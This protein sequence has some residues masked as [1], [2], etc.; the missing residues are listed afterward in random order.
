[1][2]ITNPTL[3]E[4]SLGYAADVNEIPVEN[5]AG[6]NQASFQMIFPVVTEQPIAAG[7][8]PPARADFN[9]L[10]KLLGDNIYFL[11]RGGFYQYDQGIEYD[12]GA[13]VLHNGLLYQSLTGDE[14]IGHTPGSPDSAAY[15]EEFIKHPDL[16]DFARR[17]EA[18]TFTAENT[19]TALVNITGNL[20]IGGEGTGGTAE[21]AAVNGYITGT[22]APQTDHSNKLATTEYVYTA[23]QDYPTGANIVTLDGAQT[24]TGAKTFSA[25]IIG[26][27]NGNAVNVTERYTRTTRGDLDYG[28]NNN[29]LIDKAA[30]AFWNGA[31]ADTTSNLTYCANGTIVGTTGNQTIGGNKTFSGAAT[32]KG[33]F[34][35]SGGGALTGIWTCPTPDASTEIANKSYVDAQVKSGGS[36]PT[37]SIIPYMGQG[38]VPSGY[39]LCNG[40]KVSR[41]TYAA[42]FTAI[43][44]KFGTG[45]GSTTFTLPNLNSRYLQG[46]T[47]KPGTAIAAGL[48]NISGG[49]G[50][51][52]DF[53]GAFSQT[54]TS[55]TYAW[56]D[57]LT[58]YAD[59]SASRSSSIY[60]SS[61]TVTPQSF[62]AQ[63]LIK[64]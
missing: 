25:A 57:A 59:F 27:L 60:G 62:T 18:N 1:M 5:V 20:Q 21:L 47:G 43:G 17:S 11:Q 50:G 35:G 41:T 58:Y 40:A 51:V 22:T 39:L 44:T 32:V 30:L 61:S 14:N 15:W 8:I 48:P 52:R 31:Y 56:N 34:T 33:K 49:I 28:A 23:L 36:V 19:F 10:F 63:Y 6:S 12:Q 55:V 3:W 13:I 45:D 53:A 54:G 29:Y 24:I 2:S 26:S 37:G 4:Q 7:G 46:T 16:S 42:L 9:G 38:S 64:Y